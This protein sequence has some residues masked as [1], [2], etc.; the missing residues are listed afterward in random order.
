MSAALHTYLAAE[1]PRMGIFN[2]P[3][4]IDDI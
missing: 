3:G 4:L 1:E 2:L